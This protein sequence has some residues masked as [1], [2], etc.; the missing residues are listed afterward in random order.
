[1]NL[2]AVN[3][4]VNAVLYEGYV[5]YP[6]R[7]SSVK[8]RQRWTFGGLYPRAYS[9]AQGGLEPYS[10]QTQCLVLGDE[11]TSVEVIVRFLHILSRQVRELT[12]SPSTGQASR[13]V[14]ALWVGD[15]LYQTW[16]E[17]TERDAGGAELNLS[18][19][20]SN[21]RDIP[22]AFPAITEVEPLRLPTGEQVGDIVRDQRPVDGRV[23]VRA[24]HLGDR[25]FKL[26][27]Q[28]ENLTPWEAGHHAPGED[29]AA[30]EEALLLAF[31]STHT[32]LGVA[33][34]EFVSLIDPPAECREA[35]STCANLGTWPVLVGKE[36]ERDLM[37]SSPIIL[38]DYPQVAPESPGDLFDGTE[39]DEILTLRIMTLTDDEKKEMRAVDPRARA[40][41]DRT[42]ALTADQMMDL[43][44]TIR[45]MMSKE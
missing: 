17:A 26:T 5:L 7:P 25:L 38:Y 43:H 12:S 45:S 37:L 40:L 33:N 28:V 44:G 11:T 23:S 29:R 10:M 32:I 19:L 24:E 18:D 13:P 35:A 36:G 8:N 1:M 20:L 3:S 6:Y 41:L 31:A 30:R 34:G 22:F 4:I 14:E 2:S 15:K 21:P 9:E 42:E 39:I 27:V 16:Q